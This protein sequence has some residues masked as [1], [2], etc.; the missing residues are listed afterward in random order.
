MKT[1]METAA[2][3]FPL[4]DRNAHDRIRRSMMNPLF[5]PA[6]KRARK[7][8]ELHED[9]FT[10]ATGSDC[11]IVTAGH[12]IPVAPFEMPTSPNQPGRLLAP[13]SDDIDVVASNFAQFPAAVGYSSCA[14]PFYI[15]LTNCTNTLRALL[16]RDD[17]L[18][19]ARHLIERVGFKW[20]TK[21]MP[22]FEQA[23]LAFPREAEDKIRTVFLK[24]G[25]DVGSVSLQAGWLEG[26]R[27]FGAPNDG[28]L[29]VPMRFVEAVIDRPQLGAWLA[30]GMKTQPAS[31]H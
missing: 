30:G 10:P 20:P 29:T 27:P 16:D 1:L 15:L 19:A 6:L 23:L 12:G 2:L 14:A 3:H 25:P 22:P 11:A 24:G 4:A 21:P 5:L 28:C 26:D 18:R 17:R 13:L 8:T 7:Q 9:F 31:N